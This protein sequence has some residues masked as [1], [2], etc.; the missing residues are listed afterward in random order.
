MSEE[1]IKQN[2]FAPCY[3][4]TGRDIYAFQ[5]TAAVP[6]EARALFVQRTYSKR[7]LTAHLDLTE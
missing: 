5:Q 6:E 3:F 4:Q 7:M 1:L 2:A